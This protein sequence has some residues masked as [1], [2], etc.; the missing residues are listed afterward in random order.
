MENPGK[1]RWVPLRVSPSDQPPVILLGHFVSATD[2]YSF[3]VT[4]LKSLWVDSASR[5]I[6]VERA[7]QDKCMVDVSQ[8]SNLAVLLG[9]LSDSLT[10]YELPEGT[11]FEA[12]RAGENLQV[13]V[14]L[15]L[16]ASSTPLVWIFR[17][18]STRSSAF[19]R[20]I[21]LGSLGIID[22]LQSQISALK[23]I[24][25]EKDYHISAMQEVLQEYHA[26]VY[27]P[28]RYRASFEEFNAEK[29]IQSWKDDKT[30]ICKASDMYFRGVMEC[31]QWWGW[32]SAGKWGITDWD[33]S[34][35]QSDVANGN[36]NMHPVKGK[37]K[38]YASSSSS[39]TPERS[40]LR[41]DQRSRQRRPVESDDDQSS[42]GN[43]NQI[44]FL[45]G[46]GPRRRIDSQRDFRNERSTNAGVN[47]KSRHRTTPNRLPRAPT[48]YKAANDESNPTSESESQS[49]GMIIGS[50]SRQSKPRSP[51]ISNHIATRDQLNES[52]SSDDEDALSQA[53]SSGSS[54]HGVIGG[55][56]I[57]GNRSLGSKRGT[58]IGRGTDTKATSPSP[59]SRN[60]SRSPVKELETIVRTRLASPPKNPED[61]ANERRRMLQ[62]QLQAKKR[63]PVRRR[64]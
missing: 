31:N 53:S 56:F 55:G 9:K 46:G 48:S 57:G 44:K 6:I 24:A 38:H 5:E 19:F 42:S 35:I 58:P 2:S 52:E 45:I 36:A 14:A 23:A 47:E 63:G 40:V 54:M 28:R 30:S 10:E 1:I 11:K 34:D 49:S 4:D 13:T 41:E 16:S 29:W 21:F 8:S 12:K 17:L 61:I 59:I 39:E 22:A 25:S 27:A 37:R 51:P 60:Q 33:F 64:F 62:D 20:D 3:T 32:C 43:E 15:Q 18:Q 50:R 26:N 7:M